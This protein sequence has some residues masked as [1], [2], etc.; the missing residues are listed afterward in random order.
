MEELS[1]AEFWRYAS[2]RIESLLATS[3][4]VNNEDLLVNV[5]EPDQK[6]VFTPQPLSKINLKASKFCRNYKI[7]SP[8]SDKVF[9]RISRY[10]PIQSEPIKPEPK[11]QPSLLVVSTRAVT[12][13]IAFQESMD[14]QI[15]PSKESAKE[16]QLE[17]T[18]SGNKASFSLPPLKT[19]KTKNLSWK[20]ESRI[21]KNRKII[22]E[23]ERI[24]EN[25]R[26]YINKSFVVG[27]K[28]QQ[29]VPSIRKRDPSPFSKKNQNIMDISL[30]SFKTQGNDGTS[31]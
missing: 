5:D 13:R 15:K 16:N 17:L 27:H 22:G 29:V 26:N 4:K 28:K 19:K 1:Q 24:N 30:T 18:V 20:E 8:L 23:M 12:K 10:E 21:Y 2:Q 11:M 3:V 9:E 25:S 7:Y 6:F 31:P 14:S